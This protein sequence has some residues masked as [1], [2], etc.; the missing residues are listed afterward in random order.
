MPKVC[1]VQTFRRLRGTAKLETYAMHKSAHRSSE[2]PRNVQNQAGSLTTCARARW[3][4]LSAANSCFLINSMGN[5]FFFSCFR[6]CV[7]TTRNKAERLTSLTPRSTSL[8]SWE[9]ASLTLIFGKFLVQ[10]IRAHT[11]KPERLLCGAFSL[12]QNIAMQRK[13]RIATTSQNQILESLC[14]GR[15]FNSRSALVLAFH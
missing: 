3:N 14:N 11:R 4:S 9:H 7:V 6:G 15:T 5:H 10:A 2:R 8:P 1:R 13:V 12:R